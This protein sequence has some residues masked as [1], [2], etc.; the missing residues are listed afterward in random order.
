M[1]V[2]SP[3][4]TM[5]I[6]PLVSGITRDS[7]LDLNSFLNQLL[8]LGGHLQV[9]CDSV[10]GHTR[11]CGRGSVNNNPSFNKVFFGKFKSLKVDG[12]PS[13]KSHNT[14]NKSNC[15]ELP[16]LPSFK[17]YQ[18]PMCLEWHTKAVCSANFL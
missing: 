7:R 1:S 3:A 5:E 11:M 17:V 2:A 18:K 16:D 4:P 15:G 13:T 14:R 12:K 9:P 10:R 8:A 6:G